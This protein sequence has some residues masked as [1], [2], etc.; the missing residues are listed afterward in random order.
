MKRSKALSL[1]LM[2][3]LSVGSAGCGTDR[4]DE[5][6]YTFTSLDECYTSAI[7]SEDECRDLAR[8]A[9]AETPRFSSLEECES[10]FGEGACKGAPMNT[11]DGTMVQERSGGMWMPMM[12][13]FMAGRF[14]S[15][16]GMMQ[17]S[18]GLYRDPAGNPQ[19]GRS[20][21]M[22]GGETVRPGPGGRVANPTPGMTQAMS[23]QAKPVM[24]RGASGARGGFFGG[25][26]GAAS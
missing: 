8:S 23:H 10:R 9:L 24:G 21:R 25:S 4:A 15:G 14:M 26:G 3:S 12:M 17:G 20:F 13:G 16:G 18:Q 7:F 22:A 19:Q 6:M 2:G 1:I 11:A 5:G